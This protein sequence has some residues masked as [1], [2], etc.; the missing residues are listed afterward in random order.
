MRRFLIALLFASTA[1]AEPTVTSIEPSSAPVSGDVFVH[2][3]GTDLIGFA[4]ACPTIECSDYVKFGDALGAIAVQTA[5]E[6][7]ALAPAHGAGTVDLTVNLAGKKKI[8][9]P[10]AFTYED[11]ASIERILL[12]IVTGGTTVPGALG[13]VWKAE[14]TIHNASSD[15]VSAS[16]PICIGLF[17]C[18][19]PVS[20][21]P[22]ST[23]NPTIFAAD[24]GPGAFVFVPRRSTEKVDVTLRIQ[25]VSRQSQ[26]WGTSLPVVRST[27]FKPL[28]RL[29]GVPTDPRFRLTLRIYGYRGDRGPV[30]VRMFDPAAIA[31]IA[32]VPLTLRA[33]NADRPSYLQLDPIS[34]SAVAAPPVV[35]IEVS[36]DVDSPRPIWA[37]VSVTNNE[38]QH[39]TVIAPSP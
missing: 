4:L 32:D 20:V 30:R 24:F 25:D 17:P 18:S 13:S 5:T 2:I 7:V 33:G 22:G 29:A 21:A 12:P 16:V 8:V 28:V 27:A 15:V 35:R 14:V 23:V 10:A 36:S 3:Y 31:P 6:I 26:T 1:F 9:L 34:L 11:D 37:F 39:V 38:T 19:P